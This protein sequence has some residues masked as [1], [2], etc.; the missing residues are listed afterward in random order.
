MSS[1]RLASRTKVLMAEC[2]IN[3]DV[4][5]SHSIRGSMATH[6]LQQGMDPLLVQHRGGWSSQETMQKWYARSHQMIDWD[7]VILGGG[8]PRGEMLQHWQNP[9]SGLVPTEASLSVN[10]EGSVKLRRR[11][12][13]QDL[14]LDLAALGIICPLHSKQV[15]PKCHCLIMH[16]AAFVCL[17]CQLL[18]HV[19]CLQ[20][21]PVADALS[22]MVFLPRC[23][24]CFLLRTQLPG[25]A[26]QLGEVTVQDVVDPM[27]V[28]T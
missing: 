17:D 22:G 28:C 2:G 19:R 23:R 3:T 1:E 24:Q 27:G 8:E 14:M 7:L 6:L 20:Q 5:N 21:R 25:D 16:E 12:R 26:P 10:D 13:A 4:F 11:K 9:A 18:F 15:C